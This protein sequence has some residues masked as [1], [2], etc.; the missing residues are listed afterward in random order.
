M[1]SKWLEWAPGDARESTSRATL[2]GL[3]DGLRR[4]NLGATAE[5]LDV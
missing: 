4:V 2:Q 3:K 5:D 1:L